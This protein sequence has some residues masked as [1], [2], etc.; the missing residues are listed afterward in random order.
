MNKIK[1]MYDVVKTM[2]EKEVING[3]LKVEGKKDQ[4]SFVSFENKFQKNLVTGDV[5]AKIS[6]QLDVKGK[7]IKHESNTEFTLEN[8]QL[9]MC[10]HFGK[11]MHEHHHHGAR[12][13]SFKDKLTA[14]AYVLNLIDNM[15]VLEQQDK[16]LA[17]ISLNEIPE[18]LKKAIHEKME[19][20]HAAEQHSFPI[21]MQR[22]LTMKETKIDL[23]VLI[24]KTKE[25]EKVT[26][27]VEG[28]K[29]GELNETHIMN[30]QGEL[31]FTW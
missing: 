4:V 10:H 21:P 24:S 16:I 12:C 15:Q 11:H 18:E 22:F 8:N 5:T 3:S 26:I 13:H 28:I 6:S 25:V 1:L 7:K 20:S 30:L 19:H 14:L 29:K 27:T 17:T 2:K 31:R 9:G 23:V